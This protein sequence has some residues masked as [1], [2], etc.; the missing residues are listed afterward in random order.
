MKTV[1]KRERLVEEIGADLES[2]AGASWLHTAKRTAEGAITI[3][4]RCSFLFDHLLPLPSRCCEVASLRISPAFFGNTN[5]KEQ[6]STYRTRQFLFQITLHSTRTLAFRHCDATFAAA[7][8]KALYA[9][10]FV[11]G[12]ELAARM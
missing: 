11:G 1:K 2:L 10:S 3:R 5:L 6:S 7:W 9:S 8:S 4:T 12:E